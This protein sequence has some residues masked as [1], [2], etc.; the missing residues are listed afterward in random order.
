MSEPAYQPRKRPEIFS[1]F[2]TLPHAAIGAAYLAGYAF[3]DWVSFINPVAPYIDPW[4]PP[5]GLG[6]ILVPRFGHRMIPFLFVAPILS[7]LIV[8]QSV[9]PW[10]LEFGTQSCSGS[11]ASC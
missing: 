9:F 7:D 4:N 3:L 6:F 1:R 2:F 5:T 11:K 8:R 10:M